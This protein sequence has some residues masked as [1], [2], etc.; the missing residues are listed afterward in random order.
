[1]SS[2]FPTNGCKCLIV[3]T[4][5]DGFPPFGFYGRIIKT[6]NKPGA[7]G[8]NYL[9]DITASFAGEVKILDWDAIKNKIVPQEVVASPSTQGVTETP[10]KDPAPKEKVSKT[11]RKKK[12][13]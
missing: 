10:V 4:P 5:E 7:I 8:T 3:I 1:M 9:T 6:E 13:K 2:F 11:S 12:S